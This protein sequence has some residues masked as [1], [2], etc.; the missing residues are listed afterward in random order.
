[1]LQHEGG[2]S[3]ASLFHA[4]HALVARPSTTG[5]ITRVH[6]RVAE[7]GSQLNQKTVA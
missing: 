6:V 2:S 4:G 7:P 3:G 1:M 5:E